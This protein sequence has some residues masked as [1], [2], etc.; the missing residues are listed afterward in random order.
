MRKNV[1]LNCVSSNKIG[2]FPCK[3]GL[4]ARVMCVFECERRRSC[5]GH[6]LFDFSEGLRY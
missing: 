4:D 6:K 1:I 5:R 3:W 2:N